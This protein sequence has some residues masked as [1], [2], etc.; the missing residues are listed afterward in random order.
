VERTRMFFFHLHF[1]IEGVGG[2]YQGFSSILTAA[3]IFGR[4]ASS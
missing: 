4:P 3:G 2:D 1:V